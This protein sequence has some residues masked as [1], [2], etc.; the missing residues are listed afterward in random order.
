MGRCQDQR[1]SQS[2]RFRIQ[3]RAVKRQAAHFATR[4]DV[5]AFP[6]AQVPNS[7]WAE[8]FCDL[9]RSLLKEITYSP[10]QVLKRSVGLH[11]CDNIGG[12][13]PVSGHLFP[14]AFRGNKKV[15]GAAISNRVHRDFYRG[16]GA[17]FC[18]LHHRS[19]SRVRSGGVA[20]PGTATTSRAS[21]G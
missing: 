19:N 10:G 7:V 6:G 18:G 12:F 9:M 17:A 8:R 4:M 14:F 15:R 1:P 16:I 11:S 21:L 2:M 20:S 3:R 13:S 5:I